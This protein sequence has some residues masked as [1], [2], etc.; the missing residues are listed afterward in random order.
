MGVVTLLK[1]FLRRSAANIDAKRWAMVESALEP[2]EVPIEN[3]PARYHFADG[4]SEVGYLYL[5]DRSVIM[6]LELSGGGKQVPLREIDVVESLGPWR[7]Y[8]G[9]RVDGTPERTDIE[10][11]PSPLARRLHAELVS[12]VKALRG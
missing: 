11:Y 4:A 8:I 10:M 1:R 3:V 7:F 2:D 5:T 12:R 6:L 9:R